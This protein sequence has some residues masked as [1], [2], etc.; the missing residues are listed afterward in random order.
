[1]TSCGVTF[2]WECISMSAIFDQIALFLVPIIYFTLDVKIV[3]LFRVI[4]GV[5]CLCLLMGA[6]HH[7]Q[8]IR[9]EMPSR[10]NCLYKSCSFRFSF[11]LFCRVY[12]E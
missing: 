6:G 12:Y 2:V 1:M 8:A 9:P 5:F 4:F 7:D 3:V 10:Q 11:F